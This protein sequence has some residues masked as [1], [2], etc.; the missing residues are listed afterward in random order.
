MYER[1]LTFEGGLYNVIPRGSCVVRLLGATSDFREANL[2][3]KLESEK[4]K[5]HL[6]LCKI[7]RRSDFRYLERPKRNGN[8]FFL[9]LC[10]LYT[11]S[12]E[13]SNKDTG[14]SLP[15]LKDLLAPKAPQFD[16][17]GL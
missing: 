10:R 6:I 17:S 7:R 1:L 2:S 8:T 13:K 15:Y 9:Q 11:L 3:D 4:N 16:R 14:P 5:H 12:T